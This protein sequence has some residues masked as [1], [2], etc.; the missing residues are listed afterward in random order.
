MF[1]LQLYFGQFTQKVLS[2]SRKVVGGTSN[3][4]ISKGTWF[5]GDW[6]VIS[7]P[8]LRIYFDQP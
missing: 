3:S 2:L 5:W 4:A 1:G 6:V 8:A 7:M